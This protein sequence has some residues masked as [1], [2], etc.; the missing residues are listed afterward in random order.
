MTGQNVEEGWMGHDCR[1]SPCSKHREVV[2]EWASKK[3][4]SIKDKKH[5][6]LSDNKEKAMLIKNSQIFG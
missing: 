5:E 3:S 2:Q 6:D 1:E 4:I